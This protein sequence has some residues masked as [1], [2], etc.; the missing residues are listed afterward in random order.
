MKKI[1]VVFGTRPEA[2]KMC[3]LVNVLLSKREFETKVCV[4]GQH[5]EMLDQ[6]LQTFGVKPDYDLAIM[7]TNQTLFD[8]TLTLLPKLKEV[9]EREKPELVLV[10]GDSAS[11]FISALVCFYL[12]IDIGH[13]EAGLR[14][15]DLQ[16][17]YPEEFFRQSIGSMA[18]Y[19]FAPTRKAK[20]NLIQEGRHPDS[21]Y[22]T[23]NTAI[24]ALRTTI[25]EEYT[26][27]L[28]DWA[29]DSRLIV[30][31]AHR[32]ENIGE[33]LRE[34]YRAVRRIVNEYEDVKVIYPVHPNPLVRS[35]AYEMLNNHQRIQ[36]IEPLP[37]VDFHN[38]L[39]KTYLVLTDS[40]GIQEIAPSLGK[41]VLVL[42]E[43]TERPEGIRAGTL[44]LTHTDEENIYRECKVLLSSTSKYIEMS[45][46]SN[47]YG[48]G[49]ASARIAD[50]IHTGRRWEWNEHSVSRSKFTDRGRPNR[51]DQPFKSYDRKREG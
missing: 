20:V 37:V 44:K 15:Y 43:K 8:L 31:T 45:K 1:V 25:R 34:V 41:P 5:R 33:P 40:G 42:R 18:R 7:K 3:P 48:D 4:T 51:P 23:G 26:H 22:V 49:Y 35:I 24:D 46:A 36:L 28:L 38:I 2:I 10:H 30:L 27:P 29:K 19:H 14:T 9:L 16:S 39:S 32:Q 50:I 47:P 21:I 12:K 13:V 17:P 6:V 11:S